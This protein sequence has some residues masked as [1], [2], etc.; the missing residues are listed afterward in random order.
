M[1]A[2]GFFGFRFTLPGHLPTF[3]N[4]PYNVTEGQ[5]FVFSSEEKRD[6]WLTVKESTPINTRAPVTID[7]MPFGWT[8]YNAEYADGKMITHSDTQ[9]KL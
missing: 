6:E 5:L 1:N 4:N 2:T 9:S 3:K 7:S 8:Q